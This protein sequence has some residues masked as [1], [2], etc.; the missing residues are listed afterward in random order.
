MNNL[1]KF[2]TEADY[3]AATL[4][5]PAVS[6]VESGDTM[7]Y[8]PTAPTPPTFQGKW[9]A[10]YSDS[11]TSSAD[12]DATSAI[13]QNEITATDLVSVQIGD[14][15]TS[16]GGGDFRNCSSLSS[17]TIGSSVTS[18]DSSA[19]E[20]SSLSSIDIPNSVTSIGTRAFRNCISLTSITVNATVP[21]T[22]GNNAFDYTNDCPI[23]VP[24]A[25]VD[26]YKEADNWRYYKS[27]IQAIP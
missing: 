17:C 24:S 3:S 25:S 2:A 6:W 19:F 10:T 15:V 14:C 13:T 7:H 1:K 27:R 21:P 4:N 22:L 23:Y 18:I 12:C 5:Y 16:I 8:D 26:A 9:L 20:S 11:S